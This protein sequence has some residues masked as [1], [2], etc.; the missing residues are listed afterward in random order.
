[1]LLSFEFPSFFLVLFVQLNQVFQIAEPHFFVHRL[2]AVRR[3][4]RHAHL[5]G[6]GAHAHDPAHVLLVGCQIFGG[7]NNPQIVHV[8][9]V[10]AG[11]EGSRVHHGDEGGGDRAQGQNILPPKDCGSQ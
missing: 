7:R 10:A 4:H 5:F 3:Q 2:V 6:L 11:A 9:E 1:M 8:L